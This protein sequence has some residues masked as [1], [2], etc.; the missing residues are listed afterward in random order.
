MFPYRIDIPSLQAAGVF[1]ASATCLIGL[2]GGIGF[3][4][5]LARGQ[6][7]GR[8]TQFATLIVMLPLVVPGLCGTL[9]AASA[10]STW[11]LV[12]RAERATGTV[13]RHAEAECQNSGLCYRSIIEF[14]TADGSQVSMEDQSV[15]NPPCHEL[16]QQ[17]DVVYDPGNPSRAL[18]TN[19]MW[20]WPVGLGVLTAASLVTFVVLSWRA[21]RSGNLWGVLEWIMDWLQ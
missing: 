4:V 21:Y 17:V 8:S 1:C 2:A 12:S 19:A 5:M 16:G 15:C 18:N 10:Y 11:T 3:A 13:I 9:F 7:F 14:T 20:G 6:K